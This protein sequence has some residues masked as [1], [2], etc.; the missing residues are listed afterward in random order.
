[1]VFFKTHC[2]CILP[3]HGR[4]IDGHELFCMYVPQ[5]EGTLAHCV[6]WSILVFH[7]M[8]VF[9]CIRKVYILSRN[10]K[11]ESHWMTFDIDTQHWKVFNN[12][13][14]FCCYGSQGQCLCGSI[15][16]IRNV[17]YFFTD[18]CKKVRKILFQY[19]HIILFLGHKWQFSGGQE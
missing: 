10:E 14:N 2:P 5:R 16:T 18:Q 4:S 17:H 1:M 3:Y 12:D 15:L 6:Y 19:M 11:N 7:E 13:L 9:L 8:R